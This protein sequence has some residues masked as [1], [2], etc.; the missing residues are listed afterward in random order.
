MN[1]SQ[2]SFTTGVMEKLGLGPKVLCN[3]NPG[4]IY[5]R[6]TGFGQSGPYK[7][8]AGHDINYIAT[9]GKCTDI[10]LYRIILYACL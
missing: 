3:D 5:A 4:L 8:M 6:L 10:I 7:D 2:I 9:S 1:Y